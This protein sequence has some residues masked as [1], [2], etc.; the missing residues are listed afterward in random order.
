[1]FTWAL[2]HLRPEDTVDVI[3][4]ILPVVLALIDDYDTKVKTRGLHLASILMTKKADQEFL[5]KS[6]IAG[7]LEKSTEPSLVFRSDEGQLGVDLLNAGFDAAILTARIQY[8]QTS[9]LRYTAQWWKLAER[10]VANTMYVS[11]K[12]SAM[13]VLCSKINS[14][15]QALGPAVSRYLRPLVGLLVQAMR[16]TVFMDAKMCKLHMAVVEQFFASESRLHCW[17]R[18]MQIEITYY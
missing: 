12:V 1:C 3:S 9:D 16:S 2:E 13:T 15:C 5:R 17:R 10:I 6:G 18:R 11:D 4:Y 7:I 8:T 14:V